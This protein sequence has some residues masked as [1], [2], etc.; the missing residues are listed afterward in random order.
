MQCAFDA[1]GERI[2]G[3]NRVLD[4][5]QYLAI[6]NAKVYAPILHRFCDIAPATF[7]RAWIDGP[8]PSEVD[9]QFVNV[10]DFARM[11]RSLKSEST[12]E[13]GLPLLKTLNMGTRGLF[14]PNPD[15]VMEQMRVQ[16][17]VLDD[18]RR[19]MRWAQQYVVAR[20]AHVMANGDRQMLLR[21]ESA[22]G[23]EYC[24]CWRDPV[25]R[26]SKEDIARVMVVSG[27]EA[28]F[29]RAVAMIRADMCGRNGRILHRYAADVAALDALK[30]EII[31][32]SQGFRDIAVMMGLNT[33]LGARSPF[34]LLDADIMRMIAEP[35]PPRIIVWED[36]YASVL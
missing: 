27:A 15:R 2:V 3:I 32:R 4:D 35:V 28:P 19:L 11:C 20:R 13:H 18:P 14:Y 6:R 33:R 24:T 25:C 5:A 16:L 1:V 17:Y 26:Y 29:L 36:V 34:M 9:D 12:E 10:R 21:H 8:V 31:G 22:M 30:D 7:P 23:L